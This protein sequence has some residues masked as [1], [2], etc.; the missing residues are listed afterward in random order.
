MFWGAAAWKKGFFP[1]KQ[2]KTPNI[3]RDLV[4]NHPCG[5]SIKIYIYFWSWGDHYFE[6]AK[7]L[8]VTDLQVTASENWAKT[9]TLKN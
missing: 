5:G 3:F 4:S 8:P 6:G 2:G 1:G 9:C 7:T